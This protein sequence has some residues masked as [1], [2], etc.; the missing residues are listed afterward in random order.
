MKVYRIQNE[1]L[2]KATEPSL[3]FRNHRRVARCNYTLLGKLVP[4][5]D[6]MGWNVP[7][8]NTTTSGEGKTIC[9]NTFTKQLDRYPSM[10]KL[11]VEVC[12]NTNDLFN[13]YDCRK[14]YN[15]KKYNGLLVVISSLKTSCSCSFNELFIQ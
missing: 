12:Y 3:W 6:K 14:Q 15:G 1:K 8:I 4:Q 11:G 10:L 9:S 7:H 13:A 2:K 5:D